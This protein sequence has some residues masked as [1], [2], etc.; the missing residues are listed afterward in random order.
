MSKQL[1]TAR[2]SNLRYC[3]EIALSSGILRHPLHLI[4]GQ[5]ILELLGSFSH[6][7][8]ELALL[9]LHLHAMLV[10]CTSENLL[11]LT[12]KRQLLVTSLITQFHNIL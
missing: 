3:D 6:F 2:P 5:L 1:H 4:A 9:I 7:F 11:V 12:A 10:I 8:G